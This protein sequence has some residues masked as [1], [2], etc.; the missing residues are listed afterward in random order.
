MLSAKLHNRLR[1]QVQTPSKA[2]PKV[3]AQVLHWRGIDKTRACLKSLSAVP[4]PEMSILLVA[5]GAE[6]GDGAILK[7][8]F[9]NIELLELDQNYGFAGGSNRGL[10]HC[11]S[12]ALNADY[13]WLLNNDTVVPPVT[14]LKLIEIAMANPGA[15]ALAATVIEGQNVESAGVGV[16]DYNRAK[17]YLRPLPKIGVSP[18]AAAL[19]QTFHRCQ[20]LSG[21]NL[22]LNTRALEKVG[23]FDERY[24]LYFE[25][26][27]LCLR[28]T[29]ADYACLVVPGTVIIHEGNAS[30]QGGLGL[31]R[32]YYHTR[33]RLL[34]F[35]DN[36]PTAARG[37]AMVSILSH[38]L[39]HSISLPLKGKRGRAKLYAEW[40]GLCD[41]FQGRLGRATC[42]D[43]C[44]KINF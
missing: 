33:N 24:Y 5:N 43:W 2:L 10:A 6:P 15:G 8:E 28:L 17:T 27:D 37:L 7:D 26:V 41:Y 21:S 30:T 9:P 3:V 42:L 34:F 12:P 29:R 31:W 25:D 20:W 22:L 16:I 18:E 39:R 4:Y 35:M 1:R 44:E 14:L 13:V 19:V 32:A 11:M 38:F 36:A 40:L 23:L